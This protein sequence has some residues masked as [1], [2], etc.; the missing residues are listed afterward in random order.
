MATRLLAMHKS[1]HNNTPQLLLRSNGAEFGISHNM[2]R[3]FLLPIMHREVYF[4]F[5]VVVLLD[6]HLN[7]EIYDGV[8]FSSFYIRHAICFLGGQ[9]HTGRPEIVDIPCD[10][11]GLARTQYIRVCFF[12]RIAGE[13]GNLRGSRH[14]HGHSFYL[15]LNLASVACKAGV[16]EEGQ[17]L[18]DL[19]WVVSFAAPGP[20]FGGKHQLE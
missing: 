17:K 11:A 8:P 20:T 16:Y 12:H 2:V 9:R 13:V 7:S 4:L 1:A 15:T 19:F 10:C 18:T 3:I 14:S 5:V 6:V